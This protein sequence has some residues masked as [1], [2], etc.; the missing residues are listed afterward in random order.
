MYIHR[1]ANCRE[2][3]VGSHQLPRMAN[4]EW[5][6]LTPPHSYGVDTY[7]LSLRT[8]YKK[9]VDHQI[10]PTSPSHCFLLADQAA[11]PNGS[12]VGNHHES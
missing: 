12:L 8:P 11:W 1:Y 7:Y 3:G 6:V 5:V 10:N 2:A 9:Q 4:S